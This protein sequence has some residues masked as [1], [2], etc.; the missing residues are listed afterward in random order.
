[1]ARS[2]AVRILR[3][4]SMRKGINFNVF[5]QA[6]DHLQ[7]EGVLHPRGMA[8]SGFGLL[9]IIPPGCLTKE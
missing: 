1:M 2:E 5:L 7:T 6:E 9:F 3:V 8:A 4:T